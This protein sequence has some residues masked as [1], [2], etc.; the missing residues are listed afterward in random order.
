MFIAST[1][2]RLRT[3]TFIIIN[4]IN[5]IC[6]HFTNITYRRLIYLLANKFYY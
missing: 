5:I 4:T 3:Y 2:R 1:T 6:K